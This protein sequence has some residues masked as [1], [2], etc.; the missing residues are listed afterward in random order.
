MERGSQKR[1]LITGGG[2]GIGLAIAKSLDAEGYKVFVSGRR[3]SVLEASGFAPVQ[4]DVTDRTS[5]NSALEACGEID[6]FVAN[7]GRADTAPALKLSA[8]TWDGM[9]AVN[10]SSVFHCA[11][12]V[13]PQMKTRKK[14]RFIAVASTAAL[15]GYRYTSAY[16]AAKHGVLGF[17]RCLALELAHSGVTANAVCPGFTDTPLID[18][19][20]E[21]I[22]RKTGASRQEALK[23]IVAANPQ[24]RLV[25][26]EEVASAVTWLASESAASV[27]GQAIAIDGGETA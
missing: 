11:Q 13:L 20:L 12:A 7:A 3:F 16:A 8:Q 17:I 10:L 27:N 25:T 4:M 21:N 1:A 22:Q 23:Q 2:S 14:G 6:V 26:P 9:I 18:A 24:S 15:K 5:I 19:A